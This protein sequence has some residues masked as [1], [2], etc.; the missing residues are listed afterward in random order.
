MCR[1]RVAALSARS[2]IVRALLAA[3]AVM[4]AVVALA[5]CGGSQPTA[6]LPTLAS[7]LADI[8][9]NAET[10]AE[11][12]I[13]NLK[14]VRAAAGLPATLSIRHLTGR[15]LGAIAREPLADGTPLGSGLLELSG[16]GPAILTDIGYDPLRV[17][18][19]LGVGNPPD[20]ISVVD[21]SF[22]T[23]AVSRALTRYG[24]SRQPGRGDVYGGPVDLGSQV[25]AAW[26]TLRRIA[27]TGSRLVGA[28]AGVSA[29][30]L[31]GVI[32]Q[33][34]ASRSLASDP[35]V[36]AVLGLLGPSETI[37]MGTNLVSQGPGALLGPDATREQRQEVLYRLGLRNLPRP[38]FAGYALHEG[39][40]WTTVTLYQSAPDAARA[41]PLI[42]AALRH[43]E[44]PVTEAPY[45][46]L[47]KLV[48]I[49][50]DGDAVVAT[51]G[52]SSR[53]PEMIERADLPQFF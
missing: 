29:G 42:S 21:G 43:G 35:E 20:A 34:P 11:I 15:E 23:A 40:T 2:S 13:N 52:P 14:A 27:V 7:L 36:K 51:L 37:S 44:D 49:K 25:A 46:T 53:V 26:S 1:A 18:A 8:P 16:L 19:E 3:I 30:E 31:A 5:A 41:A 28:G 9:A 38:T 24:W 17:T 4:L 32:E 33:R 10:R 48:S 45:S 12:V 22:G 6:G 47:T 39:G 50:V